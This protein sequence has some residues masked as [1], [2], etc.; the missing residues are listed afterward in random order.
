MDQK[1]I[2]LFIAEIRKEKGYT[3]RQLAEQLGASDKAISRWETGRGMPDTSIMPQLCRVLDI[4]INELLSG[5]RLTAEIYSGKAEEHMVNLMK[6]NEE[7]R[8]N[9]RSNF[10]STLCGCVLLALFIV[11]IGIF[12]MGQRSIVWFL[13]VPSLLIVLGIELL[14]LG[15]GGQ[16]GYF[17][18]SFVVLAKPEKYKKEEKDNYEYAMNMAIKTMFCG[19]LLAALIGVVFVLGNVRSPEVLG[20]NLAIAILTLFYASFFSL[21][22]LIVKGRVQRMGA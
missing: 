7:N 10:V 19:G 15:A 17:F 12:S 13:D 21:I 16:M 1:K 14:V 4:N 2:G 9:S 11:F 5:E 6:S 18:K 22:L 3:Q 20:P 8:K